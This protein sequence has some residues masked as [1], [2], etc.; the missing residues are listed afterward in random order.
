MLR[1]KGWLEMTKNNKTKEYSFVIDKNG[2]KLAPCNINKAWILIRKKK[3]ILLQKYPM[4]IQL[5]Y[6]IEDNCTEI[7]CGID[8]GSK[9][10]GISLVQKCNN[11]N[12]P[13]FKGTIELR[14]D[15]KKL[16]DS[17]REHRKYRRS[18]KR[19]RKV[20]FCNRASSK[21]K[22]R[23]APSILQKKQSIIRVINQLLKIVD[24]K[25]F[26]LE[27]VA[28]DIRALSD[29]HKPYKWQYQKTNRLD[30]NIRKA[31]ILRDNCKCKE[32]GKSNCMLEVHHIV[33]RRMHGKNNLGN[34]ITLCKKCHQKTKGKEELFIK[35]YQNNSRCYL[36]KVG[37]IPGQG[38]ASSMFNFG[39]G[40]GWIEMA[41]IANK[42]PT[43]EVTPQKWQKELQLGSKGKKSTLEWKTKLK[44]RAQQLW[45]TVE[46]QFNLKF[47]KDW[48]MGQI[49]VI[50]IFSVC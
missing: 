48:L 43:T 36:E 39:K 27:D 42:I 32:C 49:I 46:K 47:K 9:H 37:G 31:V 22:M 35:H 25:E 4:T 50:M 6:V 11:Y 45:P 18:H 33:P 15:V 1:K 12:K 13:I 44:Q 16:I 30:E 14:Q 40:F 28:I 38:G 20:R 8:D 7:I 41:L 10:V 24:I 17:R 21:R 3:A 26:H 29:G 19:Y 34:L 23:V 2:N 5:N